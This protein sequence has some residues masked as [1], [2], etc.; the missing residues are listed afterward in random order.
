MSV[1]S[2]KRRG[3]RVSAARSGRSPTRPPTLWLRGDGADGAARAGRRSRSSARARAPRTAA[4]WRGR[5]AASWRRPGSSSSA[6]WRAGSTARLTAARSTPEAS[7]SPCS[8]AESTATTR[9]LI[10]TWPAASSRGADRVGVRAGDRAGALAVPG[11]EQDHRRS[12][13]GD[14]RR[15]GARALGS[16]DHGGLRARGRARG[17]GRARRDHVGG[18]GGV[19]RACCGSARRRSRRLRTCSRRTGS[20]AWSRPGARSRGLAGRPARSGSPTALRASTSW[21]APPACAPGEV[22]AAL[23]ELELAGRVDEADG[24]YRATV[25]R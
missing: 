22:A 11:A 23:I 13:R 10:A 4:R 19:E 12:L 16:A 8:A 5:S 18:L 2:I 3:E 15:R 6:A 25:T 24:V 9:P 14:G 17:D 7:P 21:P 1:R 20:S